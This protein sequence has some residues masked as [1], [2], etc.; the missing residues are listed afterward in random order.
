MDLETAKDLDLMLK[1]IGKSKTDVFLITE[2]H[3][4]N[5]KFKM[6]HELYIEELIQLGYIEKNGSWYTKTFKG[7]VFKGFEASIKKEGFTSYLT[8]VQLWV[9]CV[10]TGLS[11]LYALIQVIEWFWN[12]R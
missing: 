12:H 9:I 1:L 3:K 10:G 2:I 8:S 7:N 4:S 5:I 6:H 11:G